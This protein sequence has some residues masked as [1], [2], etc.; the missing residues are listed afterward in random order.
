M[1]YRKMEM[2]H[3]A[4]CSTLN[5]ILETKMALETKQNLF[6]GKTECI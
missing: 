3:N 5:I 4:L 2:S 1:I 6:M